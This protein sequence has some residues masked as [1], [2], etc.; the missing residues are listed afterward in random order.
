MQDESNSKKK[1]FGTN[2]L[3]LTK[4]QFK[5][6]LNMSKREQLT[7]RTNAP[8]KKYKIRWLCQHNHQVKVIRP[9]VVRRTLR[10]LKGPDHTKS[11]TEAAPWHGQ[12]ELY[13]KAPVTW[14]RSNP[15]IEDQTLVSP[16]SHS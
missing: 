16:P 15:Q 13:F 4:P 3:T 7:F 9:G 8:E 2:N 12:D 5:V 6:F 14:K 11:P 1:N 10:M